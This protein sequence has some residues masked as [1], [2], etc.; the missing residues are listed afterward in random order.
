MNKKQAKQRI[1]E[2][3]KVIDDH[4]R[5]Y[6]V[7][8]A[9]QISDAAYDTLFRE[10]EDL[11]NVYPELVSSTSPT[12][13]VGGK[14]DGAFPK[15]EHQSPMLS[16]SDVKSNEEFLAWEKRI[17]KLLG[18]VPPA[19]FAELKFDGIAMSI[20]YE[21]GIF[22]QAAT[23]GNGVTGEDVTA[24][25]K[26]IK[27]VP[28][29]LRFPKG[30]PRELAKGRI[31][32]RGEVVM[33]TDAFRKTN[34][35]Q[36]KLG[37]KVY[38][39]PR[40]L[41]AGSVR[42]LDP[43]ITASRDLTFFAYALPTDCGQQTHDEEHALLRAFGFRSDE[44]AKILKDAKAVADF[45]ETIKQQREILD[46]D[47]DGVVIAV[48]E[49]SAF[50][51]L[52]AVGRSPRGAIAYK[53][54]ATEATTV[55]EDISVQI[56]RTGAVTPVAHLRPVQIGGVTVSRA[57]LHNEDEIKRLGVRIGDTVVVGRAGDVIP[58][59][60]GVVEELRTGKEKQFRMPTN[61]PVCGER[62]AKKEGEVQRYC[63]NTAC[64]AKHREG[65]YYFVSKA[66]LDIDGLG[67]KI[68]NVLLDQGLIQD[69]ADLFVL[70]EGDL[71]PLERF[72]Q[73]SAENL[74]RAIDQAKTVPF[75]KFIRALGIRH[76]GEETALV[77]AEQFRNL[78]TLQEATADELV[79]IPDIG[80]VVARSIVEYFSNST[81]KTFLKKLFT[82][83]VVITYKKTKRG[84]K[85][86][87]ETFVFTGE[88]STLSRNDAKALVRALGGS[89]SESVSKQT[90]AVVIGSAPGAKARRA[91]TL[92]VTIL[93]EEAFLKK[94][95]K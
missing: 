84:T 73:K 54:P 76:V 4:Q 50:R 30:F 21:N 92:G 23:R 10:L 29:T 53:F 72:G 46:F 80:E 71:V 6:Y 77:L 70:T 48:N 41:A 74:I 94:V 24:N 19:Y 2:L 47:I 83:G 91:E 3:R 59:V 67:E 75:A 51:E 14:A 27:S 7:D 15:I 18:H 5:F 13:R 44:H 81:T 1:E 69:A 86:A 31:E 43:Q 12:Q 9:P 55:L 39:N 66:G 65:L 62:L 89:V 33:T 58:D 37:E 79:A 20:I 36:K 60:T 85:L 16:L 88:L 34:N 11:E 95:G 32:V 87:G 38:A 22:V 40:N 26:T 61:C 52:G 90:S 49:N 68:I 93:T 45:F 35:E 25:V 8:D 78:D 56:G 82:N 57:T 28:L 63:Q 17:A 64:P 42:Q